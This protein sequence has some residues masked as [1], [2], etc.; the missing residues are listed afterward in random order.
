MQILDDTTIH[1][2][3]RVYEMS[4]L[5]SANRNARIYTYRYKIGNLK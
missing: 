3:V 2:S 4:Y 5:P 1:I